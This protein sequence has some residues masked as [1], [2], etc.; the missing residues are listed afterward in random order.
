MPS[1]EKGYFIIDVL[2]QSLS[3][4]KYG[5]CKL[6]AYRSPSK[7]Q[8]IEQNGGNSHNQLQHYICVDKDESFKIQVGAI[9]QSDKHTYGAVLFLDGQRV[10]GKKTFVSKTT[11]HGFKLGNGQFREFIF[12]TPKIAGMSDPD[13]DNDKQQNQKQRLQP[14]SGDQ[15]FQAKEEQLDQKHKGKKGTIIIEFYKT[16]QFERPNK[17]FR[18]H[19]KQYEQHFIEDANK[20]SSFAD[21]VRIKQGGV[22]SLAKNFDQNRANGGG[23]H[24]SN[25]H[26]NNNRYQGGGNNYNSSSNNR[27]GSGGGSYG[28][29]SHDQ[30]RRDDKYQDKRQHYDQR[31]GRT[32]DLSNRGNHDPR[33][34]I[35]GGTVTENGMII[36]YRVN[37]DE[38]VDSIIINYADWSYLQYMTTGF[39]ISD[40]FDFKENEM[41]TFLEMKNN[42]FSID[43]KGYARVRDDYNEN[44]DQSNSS[45]RKQKQANG[46]ANGQRN[47]ASKQPVVISID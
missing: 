23:Q 47:A 20:K 39:K 43:S 10:H 19:T 29:N 7:Q 2:N 21:I 32:M 46:D 26:S 27:N 13:D 18:V 3:G 33:R 1:T 8:F 4:K 15:N 12:S 14:G 35:P 34:P 45:N 17:Q 31:N 42:M 40:Y 9:D 25:N 44:E 36:D 38:L 5:S 24:S 41:K 28:H 6:Q 11:F 37:Y 22:F 16:E 30:R